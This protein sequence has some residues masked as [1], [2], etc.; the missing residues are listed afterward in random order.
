[1]SFRGYVLL[2]LCVGL[3]GCGGPEGRKPPVAGTPAK[4]DPAILESRLLKEKPEGTVLSVTQAKEAKDD[5]EVVVE[6]KVPPAT[7]K[8]FLA[9]LAGFTLMSRE[10]LDDPKTK[11][12]LECEDADT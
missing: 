10:D 2:G 5:Q 8:P 6:G 12:E 7:T 1:M 9:K 11:E 4:A 3:A